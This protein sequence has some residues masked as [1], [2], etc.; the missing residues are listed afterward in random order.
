MKQQKIYIS[1]FLL[2]VFLSISVLYSQPAKSQINAGSERVMNVAT[3]TAGTDG[4]NKDYVDSLVAG[5]GGTP[6]S[7]GLP[8]GGSIDD[9]DN[10]TAY[11]NSAP[12][13][14]ACVS[15]TRTC[16]TG[17]LSGT[18]LFASCEPGCPAGNPSWT[19]GFD[20]CTGS[21][22][23]SSNGTSLTVTDPHGGMCSSGTYGSRNFDC[24]S[25]TWVATNTGTCA[26]HST[27]RGCFSCFSAGSDVLMAD[28]SVKDIEDVVIGDALMGSNGKPTRVVSYDRPMMEAADW[29]HQ[30]LMS[31]NDTDHFITNNH[32]VL[33]TE[34]WKAQHSEGAEIEAYDLLKGKVTT[35]EI[36]DEIIL[37]GGKTKKVEKLDILEHEEDIRLYNFVLSDDPVFYVNDMAVMSFV[38]DKAGLYPV[39]YEHKGEPKDAE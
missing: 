38:P 13:G 24:N 25:G 8:W 31:I 34:G 19:V 39:H 9:G 30:R 37:H 20:T 23:A 2:T 28:G 7:C 35:L 3:P 12:V 33:T 1:T 29:D 36:G 10:V 4:V 11:Q 17:T 5:G 22:P 32:P 14:T 15:E 27:D 16:T 21:R 18:Y 26:S 6:G